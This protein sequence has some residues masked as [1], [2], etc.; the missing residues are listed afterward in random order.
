MSE[1]KLYE[2]YIQ[3]SYLYNIYK[4][5]YRHNNENI[6]HLSHKR[7]TFLSNKHIQ[8]TSKLSRGDEDVIRLLLLF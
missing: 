8:R 6:K 4:Q 2:A 5:T 1:R 3:A 7:L